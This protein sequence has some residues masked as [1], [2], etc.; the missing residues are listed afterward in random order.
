MEIFGALTEVGVRDESEFSVIAVTRRDISG[1]D[2]IK[3]G[4][5]VEKLDT[6]LQSIT[7]HYFLGTV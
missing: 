5:T 6:D 1:H 3:I 7:V 4:V 2:L